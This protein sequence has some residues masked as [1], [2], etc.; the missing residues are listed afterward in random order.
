MKV[1]DHL[2]GTFQ[3]KYE[4]ARS[5]EDIIFNKYFSSYAVLVYSY[6]VILLMIMSAYVACWQL[7]TSG[8][9]WWLYDFLRFRDIPRKSK[10]SFLHPLAFDW[11]MI[12]FKKIH[13]DSFLW[14]LSSTF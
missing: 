9:C 10:S 11:Q 1:D 6:G 8:C 7:I 3:G 12:I 5:F 14:Q 13:S 4:I 2:F